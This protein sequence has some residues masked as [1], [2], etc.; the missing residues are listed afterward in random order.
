MLND[1]ES[2]QLLPYAEHLPTLLYRC[3][4]EAAV[5]VNPSHRVR[6][7]VRTPDVDRFIENEVARNPAFKV[8]SG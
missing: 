6:L 1:S 5:M 8:S 7:F 2:L 4:L 3:T